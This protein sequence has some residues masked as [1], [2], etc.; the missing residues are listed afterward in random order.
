[1]TQIK[2]GKY[3]QELKESKTGSGTI[4]ILAHLRS[5]G[6]TEELEL[7]P[8]QDS[9]DF[10]VM[11]EE[12]ENKKFQLDWRV[13]RQEGKEVRVDYSLRALCEVIFLEPRMKIY[14][15]G[16]EVKP[17]RVQTELT[18]MKAVTIKVEHAGAVGVP[19]TP[20]GKKQR[21]N[22][23]VAYLGCHRQH[24]EEWQLSGVLTYQD[25]GLVVAYGRPGI[26]GSLGDRLGVLLICSLPSSEFKV[27]NT[28]TEFERKSEKSGSMRYPKIR[29]AFTREFKKY[30]DECEKDAAAESQALDREEYNAASGIAQDLDWMQCESCD[31]WR[32]FG[33][34]ANMTQQEFKDYAAKYEGKSWCCWFEGSPVE[35]DRPPCGVPCDFENFANLFDDTT[36]S[37][38]DLQ[39]A[40]YSQ[41]PS[42]DDDDKPLGLVRSPSGKVIQAASPA[43]EHPPTTHDTSSYS[44]SGSTTTARS[45]TPDVKILKQA[46]QQKLHIVNHKCAEGNFC[47]VHEANFYGQPIALKELKNKCA[48]AELVKEA[49][50]LSRLK[51]AAIPQLQFVD[52]DGSQIGL[53]WVDGTTLDK[54]EPHMRES[55]WSSWVCQIVSALQYIHSQDILHNDLRLSNLMVTTD[56]QRVKLIDF[57]LAKLQKADGTFS[58]EP[59]FV[60]SVKY[61]CPSVVR[62]SR[63][64]LGE[65]VDVY[66]LGICVLELATGN[67]D[68][69]WGQGFTDNQVLQLIIN[70]S[71]TDHQ[72]HNQLN[73][74]AADLSE[75]LRKIVE[76]CITVN[77]DSRLDLN[78]VERLM[79]DVT[80]R[81]K[82]QFVYHVLEPQDQ[83]EFNES[84]EFMRLTRLAGGPTDQEL[85]YHVAHGSKTDFRGPFIS[86]TQSPEWA[87]HFWSVE[88]SQTDISFPIFKID[89]SKIAEES[90]VDLTTKEACR[91]HGLSDRNA[92]NAYDASEVVFTN[93]Y[94][95]GIPA[96]AISDVFTLAAHRLD[97]DAS[98]KK[99]HDRTKHR[100]PLQ[101]MVTAAGNPKTKSYMAWNRH[102]LRVRDTDMNSAHSIEILQEGTCKIDAVVRKEGD[103]RRNV[104][105]EDYG[106]VWSARGGP[107]DRFLAQRRKRKRRRGDP[108]GDRAALRKAVVGRL[109]KPSSGPA[110]PVYL[111]GHDVIFID[112]EPQKLMK[113]AR[114]VDS[115]GSTVGKGPDGVTQPWRWDLGTVE[116]GVCS[117]FMGKGISWVVRNAGRAMA[118]SKLTLSEAALLVSPKKQLTK[119]AELFAKA[120]SWLRPGRLLWEIDGSRKKCVEA[121][122]AMVNGE[123]DFVKNAM[124]SAR[125]LTFCS[126]EEYATWTSRVTAQS[127]A[128]GGGAVVSESRG[129]VVVAPSASA[130]VAHS[131]ATTSGS[132]NRLKRPFAAA[133]TGS[134]VAAPAKRTK[135]QSESAAG[136]TRQA[137]SNELMPSEDTNV[138]WPRDASFAHGPVPVL[139]TGRSAATAFEVDSDDSDD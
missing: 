71:T 103:T 97:C 105:G 135:R 51:H 113:H 43:V 38:V 46:D 121:A 131:R 118:L 53:E 127:E 32:L 80:E 64:A 114:V 77:K 40:S 129:P 138:G 139:P 92:N 57:G 16:T 13:P 47:F 85:S 109:Y 91:R 94:S 82:V 75:A 65:H 24:A 130:V 104:T 26:H 56:G 67:I 37:Q 93:G 63:K 124:S 6:L 1:M 42:E 7:D 58:S 52:P 35:H 122:T 41:N 8:S 117:N 15:R 74:A 84:G 108:V 28:K 107:Y 68:E 78:E 34:R 60:R 116:S 120:H 70:P 115:G 126:D 123:R 90:R 29:A 111:E 61:K 18:N 102:F 133:S 54:C 125:C 19:D 62:D 22:P 132:S 59:S 30:V 36:V 48:K 128:S 101:V 110:V 81:P 3:S 89:I 44:A 10:V 137:R 100:R 134:K 31:K 66:S 50:N 96:E 21:M 4:I 95:G 88:K 45:I 14:I 69:V 9:A 106:A 72:L 49:G 2:L 33:E 17:V 39:A 11:S 23:V 119:E 73:I 86:C 5:N 99:W 136:A 79:E 25:N 98:V 27:N 20:G 87:I 112:E 83:L 55:H 12:E 76:G